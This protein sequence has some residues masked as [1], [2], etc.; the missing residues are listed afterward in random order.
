VILGLPPASRHASL[1]APAFTASGV[2]GDNL[3]LHRALA[4]AP[5]GS[6]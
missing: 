1:V 6:A 5:P 2:A 4:A 3:V